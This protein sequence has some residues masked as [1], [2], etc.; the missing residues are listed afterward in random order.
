MFSFLRASRSGSAHVE[1]I[2]P[3]E[4]VRRAM[5]GEVVLLDVRDANE[6][7]ATGRAAGAVHVPMM[8]LRMKC[9]PSSP[10]CLPEFK[11]GKPIVV[12]CATGARSQGA[13]QMLLTMG[14]GP[15]F[16]LGGLMHWQAAGGAITR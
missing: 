4:A 2:D 9:D 6:L 8:A 10:E 14:H 13:G 11:T 7:R 15:V 5:S 12:Y 16:N 3:K 1:R